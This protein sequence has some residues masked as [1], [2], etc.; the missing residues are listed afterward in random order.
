[1]RES[2]S[3]LDRALQRW[4]T[5]IVNAMPETGRLI[6]VGLFVDGKRWRRCGV[7]QP[8][9]L[10][11]DL[12]TT[13]FHLVVDRVFGAVLEYT[14]N[15]QYILVAQQTR[16]FV[17]LFLDFGFEDDLH[18][19]RAVAQIDKN[20]APVVPAAIHPTGEHDLLPHGLVADLTAHMTATQRTHRIEA[21]RFG[22]HLALL[23]I[24][25]S[26]KFN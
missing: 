6:G 16:A 11:S 9:L 22:L 19:A 18:D 1:M 13:G 14:A 21:D 15:H 25:S 24:L 8:Q 26:G 3:H 5:Q 12:D 2:V 23:T 20:H 17:R 4:T 10:D 7:Q